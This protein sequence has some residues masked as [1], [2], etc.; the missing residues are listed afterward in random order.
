[1]LFKLKVG[2]G[3]VSSFMGPDG[4]RHFPGDVVELPASYQT[5][6]WLEP[7]EKKAK[8]VAAPSKVEP[9]ETIGAPGVIGVDPAKP[10]PDVPLEKKKK[11]RK[12]LSS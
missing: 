3:S 11:T 8:V 4:V 6:K 10:E 1:M 12:Q 5:E 9:A 2:K 7:V